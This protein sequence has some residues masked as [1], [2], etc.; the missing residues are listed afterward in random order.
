MSGGWKATR[1][2]DALRHLDGRD[3]LDRHAV[4]DLRGGR[5][6]AF[7]RLHLGLVPTEVGGAHPRRRCRRPGRRRRQPLARIGVKAEGAQ[8]GA[9]ARAAVAELA[10]GLLYLTLGQPIG[11]PI[12]GS[13]QGSSIRG[14]QL[15]GTDTCSC[16]SP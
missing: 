7:R 14:P 6:G 11:Q 5:W 16:N 9:H 13:K 10:T 8:R 1:W 4:D 12:D 3:R 15:T 2:D